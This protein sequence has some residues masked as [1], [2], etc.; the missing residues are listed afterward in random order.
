MKK[1]KNAI[2]RE[3]NTTSVFILEN[4]VHKLEIARSH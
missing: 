4:I 3:C 1:M 2:A